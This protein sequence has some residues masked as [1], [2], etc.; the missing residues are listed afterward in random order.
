MTR[1][2]PR[3]HCKQGGFHPPRTGPSGNVIRSH[4]SAMRRHEERVDDAQAF[5][6]YVQLAPGVLVVY[7]RQ[8]WRVVETA[9][10]PTDL[11]DDEYEKR[12]AEAVEAWERWGRGDRPEK[13]TWSSRP[14][15]I[16]LTPDGKP[17]EKPVHLIG[18]YHFSWQVLPEHYAICSACGELPPCRHELAEREADRQ[19]ASASV[20]MDIPPGHCLGCGEHI[21]SRQQATRFPGPNL[22][23]FDLSENSAV[24]HA[25]RECSTPRERYRE[26]WE[27]RG[28]VSQQ[29]GLFADEETP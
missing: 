26:Q 8:P 19:A 21:T 13:A 23:R 4:S 25:R 12:F 18:P 5:A 20:L 3:E 11:W 9:E 6:N 17:H 14:M 28:G 16:V 22:W 7:D 1:W 29:A 24:F 2:Y 27:Q 10:R 15:V